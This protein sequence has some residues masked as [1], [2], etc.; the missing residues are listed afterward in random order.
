MASTTKFM[1]GEEVPVLL[2]TNLSDTLTDFLNYQR[3]TDTLWG[4]DNT[5]KSTTAEEFLIIM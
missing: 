5:R 3:N 2:L 1:L 4:T